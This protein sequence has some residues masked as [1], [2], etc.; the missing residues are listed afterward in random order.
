MIIR[1]IDHQN[2]FL[3]ILVFLCCK[4]HVSTSQEI[5]LDV[6]KGWRMYSDS[7]NAL[8]H[9]L[10]LQAIPLWEKREAE[11][12]RLRTKSDWIDRQKLV[13][14]T[15]LKITGPFPVKTPLNAQIR[16]IIQK[17]GYRIEKVIFESRP[18]FFVTGI[19]YVPD[20]LRGKAPAIL[21]CSGH[22][23]TWQAFRSPVYQR[24][25]INF[26]KKGFIVFAYDPID[27]GERHQYYDA[28]LG[29]NILG[30]PTIKHSYSG[31]Q[32][33]ITGSSQAHYVIWDGVR[34]IDYLIS[35]NDV[36]PERIGVTGHSGGGTQ[37]AYIAAIDDRISVAAPNCWITSR[38]RLWES[39]GP[40]DAEQNLYRE[41][42]NGLD[43][44]DL[45]EVRVPEPTLV[46]TTTR[47]FFSIQGAR[48]V[49]KETK[50]AYDAFDSEEN[51]QWVEDDFPH[52]V[53]KKNAEA[54]YSF[55]QKHFDLPGD[56]IYHQV[57]IPIPEELRVS[58]TGILPT[59][60]GLKGETTFSLNKKYAEKLYS[61][62]QKSRRNLK[63]HLEN[64]SESAKKL[65]GYTEPKMTNDVV[66]VGRYQRVGY[67][68]EKYFIYGE[69]NYTIPFLLFVPNERS[70]KSPILYLHSEGKRHQSGPDEEIE[71]IVKQGHSVLSPDLI[72]IG[73]MGS[74]FEYTDYVNHKLGL[75]SARY[76]Y[77]AVQLGR[78]IAGIHA[79][80]IIRL[81]NFLKRSDEHSAKEVY[82]VARG[83]V[84]PSLI[85]VAAFD[86]SISRIALV[87]PL[88]SYKSLVVNK[89]YD[90]KNIFF[91]VPGALTAYDLPDLYATLAPR[92][93]LMIN[94]VDHLG[95]RAG[96]NMIDTA[97]SIVKTAYFNNDSE[98]LDIVDYDWMPFKGD[99]FSDWLK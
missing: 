77:Q 42:G 61:N 46:I 67:K 45:L 72:G 86:P 34:A 10:T 12:A 63:P 94:I 93:L 3:A 74:N 52:K 98:N 59:S 41:I 49:E 40:Q 26:V 6:L 66:F 64:V 30:R 7:E 71:W 96:K 82:A 78:S 47:D 28:A 33:F 73:E 5:D 91:A 81:V 80:D 20:D 24:V 99:V 39:I 65:S 69:G 4:G 83:H 27:Q 56:S 90:T 22:S 15:L 92:K 23:S 68:I 79:G 58:E 55:F 2:L 75:V 97:L 25:I 89:Y 70:G 60:P 17:D 87:E 51:F 31:N 76:W 38:K 18:N 84:C 36:D 44:A 29:G 1:F 8:Y 13:K 9:H 32:C 50:Q 35:R 57:E 85:H 19:L 53:T 43:V 16:G 48:E 14:E 54:R 95:N 21:Y 62:I 11:I 37:S 88:I